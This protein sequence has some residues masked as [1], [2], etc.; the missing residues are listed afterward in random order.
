[1]RLACNA[2]G[3]ATWMQTIMGRRWL[4]ADASIDNGKQ[5]ALTLRTLKR[6]NF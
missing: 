6:L 1:L 3:V 2:A 5:A 4:I